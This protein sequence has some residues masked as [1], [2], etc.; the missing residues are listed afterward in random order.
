MDSE[1]RLPGFKSQLYRFLA[2]WPWVKFFLAV[3][4]LSVT[5]VFRKMSGLALIGLVTI[6][7]LTFIKGEWTRKAME[8]SD[9]ALRHIKKVLAVRAVYQELGA[10]SPPEWPWENIHTLLSG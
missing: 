3:L 6:I 10:Y 1:A 8:L 5:Y 9:L 7:S 2:L 4:C